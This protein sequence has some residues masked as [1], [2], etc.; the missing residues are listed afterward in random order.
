MT[1][2]GQTTLFRKSEKPSMTTTTAHILS[3][4]WCHSALSLLSRS[5][6]TVVVSSNCNAPKLYWTKEKKP[7]NSN[8]V[9]HILMCGNFVTKFCRIQVIIHNVTH[10]L[11]SSGGGAESTLAKC[12]L[13]FVW[14]FHFRGCTYLV[15]SLDVLVAISMCQDLLYLYTS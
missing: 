15:G 1:K 5:F 13:L 9:Q 14:S 4:I 2:K 12:S 6:T 11:S 10:S 8:K 3:D 7:S